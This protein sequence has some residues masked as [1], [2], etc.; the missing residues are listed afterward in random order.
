MRRLRREDLLAIWDEGEGRHGVDKALVMLKR[1]Y[2]ETD[3]PALASLPLG[4]RD[5]R[6]IDLREQLVGDQMAMTLRC[7]SCS[8]AMALTASTDE[9]RDR[10]FQ[11]DSHRGRLQ[12]DE[13]EIE[14]RLP[15]SL[16]LA[17]AAQAGDLAAVRADI[18]RRCVASVR[19]AGVSTST[20][21]LPESVIDAL[22]TALDEA[23]PRAVLGFPMDCPHC[24][25]EWTAWLD[26]VSFV[27]I[28][29]V[30]HAKDLLDDVVDLARAFG[31]SEEQILEMSEERRAYYLER[32]NA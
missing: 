32:L 25:H 10:N 8:Q 18:I 26:V 31:W 6:L 28:E 15:S 11:L 4:E 17:R 16:D 24:G 12:M 30:Q 2:P 14:Y 27:W 21:A 19:Q 5:A 13:F 22:A 7:P 9:L 20:E 23:D 1:A 29:L 3:W